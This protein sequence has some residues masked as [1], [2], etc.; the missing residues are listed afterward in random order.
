VTPNVR[1]LPPGG[2]TFDGIAAVVVVGTG[3]AGMTAALEAAGGGADVLVVS[4]DLGGGSTP[5][6]QGGLAAVL[7]D[8]DSP[9][10]H[11][12]DTVSAGAGL[13]DPHAVDTLV[14]AGP[15]EVARLERLGARF[16]TRTPRLEGGHSRHRIVHAGGDA[17]GAEVHRVLAGAVRARRLRLWQGTMALD[18]VLDRS[19]AVAGLLVGRGALSRSVW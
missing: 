1:R 17:S 3:A 6:A 9:A 12:Q 4:K 2:V 7:G 14:A 19:G 5:W 15:A 18:L 10:L 8:E 16:D 11:R 13:C